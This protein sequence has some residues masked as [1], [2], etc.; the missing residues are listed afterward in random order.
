MKY[1]VFENFNDILA[2][3]TNE[4]SETFVT[5]D[6][7]EAKIMAEQCQVESL[8]HS[9]HLIMNRTHNIPPA[10]EGFD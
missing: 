2:L 5:E 10:V 9:N 7:T 6:L 8:F 3:V 4:A 1:V